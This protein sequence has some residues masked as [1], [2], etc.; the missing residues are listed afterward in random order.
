MDDLFAISSW[1]DQQINLGMGKHSWINND[2]DN[3]N[4]CSGAI[5]GTYY[6]STILNNNTSNDRM[7]D[8]HHSITCNS[9]ASSNKRAGSMAPCPLAAG[10][11][12][13]TGK[14]IFRVNHQ[15]PSHNIYGHG[16]GNMVQQYDEDALDRSAQAPM[17]YIRE[18]QTTSVGSQLPTANGPVKREMML[19]IEASY[20][21][22]KELWTNEEV[23]GLY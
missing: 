5:N 7:I 17:N 1:Q 20:H 12:N 6:C 9:N 10:R 21:G 3:S 4:E 8:P 14:Q 18:R 15:H 22:G 23:S 11:S 13:S 16:T 2:I 19:P